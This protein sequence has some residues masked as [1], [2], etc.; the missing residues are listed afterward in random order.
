MARGTRTTRR[1]FLRKTTAASAVAVAAPY[2]VPA[3]ALGG[4]A[5]PAPSDKLGIGVIGTGGMGQGHVGWILGQ[6][7]LVLRAV[8]DVD[9]GHL[10]QALGAAKSSE[11]SKDCAGYSDFREL[12]AQPG[13]DAVWVVTP[14]H[15]HALLSIAA[16]QA[17]K[18]IYCQKPLANSIGEGRAMVDAARKHGRVLQCGSQERS[19]PSVRYACELV[20]S[21]KLG[22]IKTIQIHLPCDDSHHDVARTRQGK[23]VPAEVPQELDY[24]FWLGHTEKVPYA[25]N[26]CHFWWR[27]NS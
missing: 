27:F 16:A 15:W 9:K 6:N 18:D 24:D 17:G 14:D 23:L 10:Q 12:L 19:T 4:A 13:I 21:G 22:E 11:S 8:C 20:R 2:F 3:H 7:D 25:E 26:R 5:G 1:E